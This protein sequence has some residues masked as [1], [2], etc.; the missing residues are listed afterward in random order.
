MEVGRQTASP[1]TD[2]CKKKKTQIRK[3][4]QKTKT[5]PTKKIT[6]KQHF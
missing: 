5:K 2:P 3:A 1:V 6:N 4:R